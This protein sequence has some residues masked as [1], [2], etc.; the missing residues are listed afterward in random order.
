MWD[1]IFSIVF[2]SI[3][4]MGSN[5]KLKLNTNVL[6]T[7]NQVIDLIPTWQINSLTEYPLDRLIAQ[8]QSL[9]ITIIYCPVLHIFKFTGVSAIQA[10]TS[11]YQANKDVVVRVTLLCP[12]TLTTRHLWTSPSF[13]SVGGPAQ[14]RGDHS[15]NDNTFRGRSKLKFPSQTSC[16][17]CET[18]CH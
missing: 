8:V 18:Y 2:Y 1:I 7:N 12:N 16:E 11:K 3:Y 4:Y 10:Y 13:I 17:T 14:G 6:S 5:I 15:E 9:I